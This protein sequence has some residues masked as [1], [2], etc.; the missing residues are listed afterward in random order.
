MI[1]ARAARM[2]IPNRMSIASISRI[3]SVND[4]RTMNRMVATSK[5]KQAVAK[6]MGR[7]PLRFVP[8]SEVPLER[9]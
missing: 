3:R 7:G 4:D 9:L 8:K 5:K 1:S 2:A 6:P